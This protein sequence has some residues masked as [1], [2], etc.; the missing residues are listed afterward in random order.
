MTLIKRYTEEQWL[1][2]AERRRIKNEK[3]S[4]PAIFKPKTVLIKKDS[5]NG[6]TRPPFRR[7]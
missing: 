5:G 1:I 3:R 7:K 2:E 6:E 4:K